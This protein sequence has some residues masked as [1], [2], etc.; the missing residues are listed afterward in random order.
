MRHFDDFRAEAWIM[1]RM[2]HPCIIQL[3]AFIRSPLALVQL[4]VHNF[5]LC[6]N[7]LCTCVFSAS[8]IIQLLAFIR[9]CL[10]LKPLCG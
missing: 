4:Y 10:S 8:C 5:L 2:T 3:L 9:V 1:K 6:V 7:V